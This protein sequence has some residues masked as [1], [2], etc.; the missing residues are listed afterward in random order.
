[1]VMPELKSRLVALLRW[2]EKYTKTDM[3]YLTTG[4]AWAILGTIVSLAI[5]A[6]TFLAFAN[7][8]PKESYGTY[9]YIL[10]V[11]DI[12]G[13]FVLSGID[14]SIARSTARDMEGSLI[15]GILTKIRWGLIGGA[16][17]VMLGSYYLAHANPVLGWGFIIA[18]LFIPFWETPG[19]YGT[20]LQ[21]K[22]RFDLATI[23]DVV[24]QLCSALVLI[25]ALFITNNTLIILFLYLLS[26]GLARVGLLLFSL[27]KLPPNKRRDPEMITYGKHLSVITVM[28]TVAS[29][30]DTLIV[31]H[32]LGPVSV[33]IYRFSQSIPTRVIGF[34]KNIN[35]L[36]WPKMAAQDPEVLRRTLMHKIWLLVG[37]S[38][39][40]ALAYA[41]T[42]PFIFA[43]FLPKYL[44]SVRYTMVV[45]A[46][47]A[48]QPFSLIS[49]AFSAQAK[50]QSLYIWSIV[51]PIVRI[52]L[53]LVCI[54][55]WG[56]WG[57]VGSLIAAKVIEN[58]LLVALFYYS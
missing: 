18:G 22:K 27:W 19:V 2:S 40:G 45:A 46:L 36:A 41:I 20:Y 15:E 39:L 31:W 47:I 48:L 16:G 14:S 53:F 56:L 52:S 6:A 25:P 57:A 4:G 12:F 10:S 50:K 58:L 44:E 29:S 17:A 43:L 5:S 55:L 30:A 35:R 9:Q 21:G 42:A 26:A 49:S 3:V 8:F 7:L 11:A 28:S 32:L 33:A 37:V 1:M 34:L 51:S 24:L 23:G 13:I 38:T 54:P